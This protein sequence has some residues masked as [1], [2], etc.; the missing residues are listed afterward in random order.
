VT[1]IKLKY[2]MRDRDRHGN[3]R[4]YVRVPGKPYVRLRGLPGSAEFMAAY[5]AALAE[6]GATGAKAE[7]SLDWLCDRYYKSAYFK[8][9][10]EKTRKNKRV[11]LDEVCSITF[12][13]GKAVR[14]LGSMPFARMDKASVRKLRDMKAGTPAAANQ[15]LK[16]LCALFSWGVKNEVAKFNPAIGV[17]KL[18][19]QK[20]GWY[21]WTEADAAKYEHTWP[22]GTQ[23]RLAYALLIY[24]GVRR[25]DVIL[26]GSSHESEDGSHIT[27]PVQKG[28]LRYGKILTL[29]V[30]PPLREVI[31]AT[32]TGEAYLLTQGG[33]PHGSGD[34]FGNWFRDA[35]R[36]AG[37]VEG[38]PH[39]LR[40]IAAVRC[41]EAGATAFEMMAMF[42]WDKPD[43][44]LTYIRAAEQK[45]MALAAAKKMAQKK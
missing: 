23:E 36:A 30:L 37:I 5:K 35:V 13:E 3:V 17:E 15:R 4:F 33:N 16:H 8:E 14:R 34:S 6:H 38:S 22:I 31:N 26:L 9:L 19:V 2:I 28:R 12:G 43:M 41:A 24:L 21:T 44:A 18:A 32:E 11:M 40:K 27:F 10:D 45:K 20:G 39:G 29:P 1:S 7:K 42:G 25:S